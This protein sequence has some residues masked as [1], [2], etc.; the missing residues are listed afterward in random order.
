M[1][2][3]PRYYRSFIAVMCSCS[4]AITDLLLLLCALA[5][6]QLPLWGK[7]TDRLLLKQNYFINNFCNNAAIIWGIC[8][9]TII[10]KK[11]FQYWQ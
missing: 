1:L 8:Y 6:P 7:I 5:S 11:T 9:T 4:P 2:L 10:P 3:Q